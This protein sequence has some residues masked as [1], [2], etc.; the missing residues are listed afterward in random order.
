MVSSGSWCHSRG[1]DRRRYRRG[2]A[3]LKLIVRQVIYEGT[4]APGRWHWKD[5]SSVAIAPS[6]FCVHCSQT[7]LGW[8]G[9]GGTVGCADESGWR[10][11]GAIAGWV[12]SCERR[13]K[14]RT[15]S[16]ADS[17][18]DQRPHC[19]PPRLKQRTFE[20]FPKHLNTR[21][22]VLLQ[23]KQHLTEQNLNLNHQHVY[24]IH[25][26]GYFPKMV[27]KCKCKAAA[28]GRQIRS[29]VYVKWGHQL[30]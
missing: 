17:S 7:G 12:L 18:T 11:E 13:A 26:A 23:H 3:Q 14:T 22:D 24:C 4:G 6:A 2:R 28:V 30:F 25:N 10:E 19:P 21:Q 1:E 29:L 15:S 5:R 27:S 9:G 20:N 16:A 8:G